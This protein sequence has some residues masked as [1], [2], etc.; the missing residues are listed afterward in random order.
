[1]NQI[2]DICEQSQTAFFRLRIRRLQVRALPSPIANLA[3]LVPESQEVFVALWLVGA[4]GHALFDGG[5]YDGFEGTL[6]NV[7][8]DAPP[9]LAA[10]L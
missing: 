3:V 1:M 10:A 5:T 4:H 6:F 8:R 2:F 9:N 7:R